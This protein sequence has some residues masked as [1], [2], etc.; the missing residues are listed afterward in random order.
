MALETII[1]NLRDGY[2]Q[3]EP[4]TFQHAD[5]LTAAQVKDPSLRN[6]CFYT[7]DGPLYSVEGKK[8][9]PTLWLTRE[10]YNLVLRHLNDNVNSSYE[11]LVKTGTFRP[12]LDEARRAMKAKST[13]RIDLSILHLPSYK[14]QWQYLEISTTKYD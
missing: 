10:P 11:Q 1:D 12:G 5:Q 9:T 6:Q 3:L 2:N 7:A 8:K 4:S 13:L 14:S